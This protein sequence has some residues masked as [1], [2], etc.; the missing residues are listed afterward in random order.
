MPEKGKERKTAEAYTDALVVEVVRGDAFRR[1]NLTSD[2]GKKKLN[3][4][5]V[6]QL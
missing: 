2:G 4:M 1:I 6:F 3:Q 5:F